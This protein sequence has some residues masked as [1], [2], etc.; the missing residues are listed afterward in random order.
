MPHE[1]IARTLS[2]GD[3]TSFQGKLYQATA[4]CFEEGIHPEFGRALRRFRA[5]VE[6]KYSGTRFTQIDLHSIDLLGRAFKTS[7]IGSIREN[8]ANARFLKVD[9]PQTP[10]DVNFE[11]AFLLAAR[12]AIYQEGVANKFRRNLLNQKFLGVDRA[13]I[14]ELSDRGIRV[15]LQKYSDQS[16]HLRLLQ[17]RQNLNM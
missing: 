8:Y 15:A 17:A 7:L 11:E 1:L 9:H 16:F 5:A 6:S 12:L 4:F 10:I 14:P 3:L 13:T 2:G